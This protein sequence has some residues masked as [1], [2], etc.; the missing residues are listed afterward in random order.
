MVEDQGV[1]KLTNKRDYYEVLGIG[2]DASDAEIKKAYRKLA[3]KYHPDTNPG[4]IRAEQ[5]FK[6]AGEAYEILSDPEKREMYDRFGHG[7]FDGTASGAYQEN[8][9]GRSYHEFHFQGGTSDDIF[10]DLFGSMFGGRK[11]FS[12]DGEDLQGE[13]KISFDDAVFGC[14]KVIHIQGDHGRMQSLQI[15]IP[16]G[17]ENGKTIRLRGK[18]MSGSGG[19]APGDFL[20]KVLVGTKN[21][22]ERRGMDVY[23]TLSIPFSMAALGGET[24]IQTLYGKVRCHIQEGTQSGT[25]IRLRGKGIVSMKNPQVHGDQ[26]VTVQIQVPK[27]LNPAAR[28]KL[29]EFVKLCA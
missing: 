4:D 23:T 9:P 5:M 1:M 8:G 6:E 19:G 25:K 11:G 28:E 24:E 27:N 18:G 26:Y 2:R 7:A 3:K 22:Y 12:R 29:K 14:E 15:K 16:A 13:V 10:E 20:L 21:G 17:I